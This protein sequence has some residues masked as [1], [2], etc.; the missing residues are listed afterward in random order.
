MPII[1]SLFIV[2]KEKKAKKKTPFLFKLIINKKGKKRTIFSSIFANN[3]KKPFDSL[4]SPINSD[5][6]AT[7]T[8]IK[9]K[10]VGFEGEKKKEEKQKN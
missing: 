7:P 1:L 3:K 2:K 8:P 10:K 5:L 4:Q 9:Q 6:T